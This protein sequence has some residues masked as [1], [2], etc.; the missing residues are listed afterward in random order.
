MLL[1]R[2]ARARPIALMGVVAF[3][4]LGG[5]TPLAAD[6]PEARTVRIE[7]GDWGGIWTLMDMGNV[8]IAKRTSADEKSQDV[9]LQAAQTYSLVVAR[10][11]GA[12]QIRVPLSEKEAI[13]T[14][15]PGAIEVVTGTPTVL[16]LRLGDLTIDS[17]TYG[18][19]WLLRGAG[20]RR[21]GAPRRTTLRVV[22]GVPL[23]FQPTV[24][25]LGFYMMLGSPT[26]PTD[27]AP[28]AGHPE[29]CPPFTIH[30]S[31]VEGQEGPYLKLLTAR[32]R[33]ASGGCV[34]WRIMGINGDHLGMDHVQ[35]VPG[36]SYRL[37]SNGADTLFHVPRTRPRQN[38]NFAEFQLACV[39]FALRDDSAE[40]R[41][42][43]PTAMP[44][45][46]PTESP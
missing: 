35:L 34:A 41:G 18:G 46:D 23:L 39:A 17:A 16:K 27:M 2:I 4:L 25:S 3:A 26:D 8:A 24:R 14:T 32:V 15:T 37:Q 21:P 43:C 31:K 36:C 10:G 28:R 5:V 11:A 45:A 1:T 42:G 13:T 33:V 30:E 22:R 7:V 20:G 9:A 19:S 40:A 38:R 44:E 6:A 12:I 29:E